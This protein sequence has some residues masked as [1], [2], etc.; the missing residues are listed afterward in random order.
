MA[1]HNI[2]LFSG[3]S[4]GPW[5][6][7]SLNSPAPDTRDAGFEPSGSWPK[8][9][10][11]WPATPILGQAPG[12]RLVSLVSP[13]SLK[14]VPIPWLRGLCGSTEPGVLRLPHTR[15]LQRTVSVGTWERSSLTLPSPIHLSSGSSDP[16]GQHQE[17]SLILF[18]FFLGLLP[19]VL[20]LCAQGLPAVLRGLYW[21]VTN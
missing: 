16:Q 11:S 13:N 15:S 21:D 20:G 10:A 7:G 8:I 6:W 17:I 4:W 3:V 1:W 2:P 9:L 19:A 14:E 5:N 18:Y 12:P